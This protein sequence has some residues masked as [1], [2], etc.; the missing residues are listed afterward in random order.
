MLNVPGYSPLETI[1]TQP[2]KSIIVERATATTTDKPGVSVIC[3]GCAIADDTLN[4]QINR[5]YEV[6]KH[7]HNHA[8]SLSIDPNCISAL[9]SPIELIN[10]KGSFI[11]V[12]EDIGGCSL[13]EYSKRNPSLYE[14][15]EFKIAICSKIASALN[16][17]HQAKT[18]HKDVNPDNIVVQVSS[19]GVVKC[20]L[21]DFS[22]AEEWKGFSDTNGS[23]HGTLAYMA[24]EQTGRIQVG[25]DFRTA[26]EPVLAHIAN[27]KVPK[28]ISKI[29]DRMIAKSPEARYQSAAGLLKDLNFCDSQIKK[30]LAESNSTANRNDIAFKALMQLDDFVLGS[31]DY[32]KFLLFSDTKIVGRSE[33]LKILRSSFTRINEKGTTEF[34]IIEGDEGQGKKS[35]LRDLKKFALENSTLC[36]TGNCHD[37]AVRP[38]EPALLAAESVVNQVLGMS[39]EKLATLAEEIMTSLGK[40]KL[41]TL[42]SI[43]PKLKLL[44]KDMEEEQALDDGT[45]SSSMAEEALC[46]FF[47][48]VSQQRTIMISLLELENIHERG[49]LFLKELSAKCGRTLIIGLLNSKTAKG[50]EI[51]MALENHIPTFGCKVTKILLEPLTTN[52]IKI[53]LSDML[54]PCLGNLDNLSS[55]VQKRTMGV[56]G[57]IIGFLKDAERDNLIYFSDTDK[58]AGW[59]WDEQSLESKS[60]VRENVISHLIQGIASLGKE[61]CCRE[62]FW[63]SL[64]AELGES[65]GTPNIIKRILELQRLGYIEL[66]SNRQEEKSDMSLFTFVHETMKQAA[67]DLLPTENRPRIHLQIARILKRLSLASNDPDKF[68]DDLTYQYGKAEE[69]IVEPEEVSHAISVAS[70]YISK[71]ILC[72]AFELART[73]IAMG[74]RMLHKLADPWKDHYATTYA[75]YSQATRLASAG[76]IGDEEEVVINRIMVE[77]AMTHQHFLLAAYRMGILLIKRNLWKEC[78]EFALTSLK[79]FGISIPT[80]KEDTDKFIA[81]QMEEFK[82]VLALGNFDKILVEKKKCPV[83]YEIIQMLLCAGMTASAILV[84]DNLTRCFSTK[85]TNVCIKY[86]FCSSS[87]ELTSTV[88]TMG[89]HPTHPNFDIFRF[90]KEMFDKLSPITHPEHV[91]RGLIFHATFMAAFL[92]PSCETFKLIFANANWALENRVPGLAMW[93]LYNALN[94]AL[95]FSMPPS[96]WRDIERRYRKSVEDPAIPEALFVKFRFAALE[97]AF[98]GRDMDAFFNNFPHFQYNA[99]TGEFHVAVLI[100]QAI[101]FNK[102]SQLRP[103]LDQYKNDYLTVAAAQPMIVDYYLGE[104]LAAGLEYSK[105]TNQEEKN[106]LQSKMN[107]I[108][109]ILERFTA[110]EPKELIGKYFLASAEKHVA[111]KNNLAALE[112][113]ESAIET[114]SR[115]GQVF[116]K[117]ISLE[118]LGLFLIQS[119]LGEIGRTCII[120]SYDAWAAWGCETKC[121]QMQS[122]YNFNFG[123]LQHKPTIRGTIT[124]GFQGTMVG[125]IIENSNGTA[126]STLD[127]TLQPKLLNLDFATLL[128]VTESIRN[129][130][131]LTGLL[132]RIMDNVMVNAGATKGALL[133]DE[134][135]GIMIKCIAT[136][137]SG[138]AQVEILEN[139]PMTDSSLVPASMIN[140]SFRSRESLVASDLAKDLR[141]NNDPYI[142]LNKPKTVLCCPI[143]HYSHV[144]G[145]VYLENKLQARTFT[146]DR[147]DFLQSLMP[148]TSMSIENARLAKTNTELAM[149]LKNTGVGKVNGPRYNINAPVQKAIEILQNLKQK[150]IIQ[151]DP[152]VT[153]IDFI[154]N[155]LI[156]SDL[157]SSSI[158]EIND[159]NG[160]G[161]D[162]DTKSW[163]ETSLLQR[164][165]KPKKSEANNN[166][167]NNNNGQN[168]FVKMGPPK[169]GASVLIDDRAK[170]GD[171]TK[172]A[173]GSRDNLESLV[174]LTSSQS[175]SEPSNQVK[176]TVPLNR[177]LASLT[178]LN[179]DDIES[180]LATS[181]TSLDFDIFRLAGL[182]NGKPLFYLSCYMMEVLGLMEN[183]NINDN[184]ARAFFEKVENSYHNLPYHNSIHASDV[185]QTVNMLLLSDDSIS[186]NFTK[187]EIFAACVASAVHDIDHPGVN[188]AFLVQSNHPMAIMYND[189]AVLESH[190][191]AKAFEIASV[192]EL[193]IFASLTVDQRREARKLIIA[194]VIATDMSQHFQYINKLKG[195]IAASALKWGESTDRALILEIAIK[196]GDL[197]NPTKSLEL[198]KQWSFRVMD[199]FFKQ[200][201]KPF[202]VLYVTNLDERHLMFSFL[203]EIHIRVIEKR[204]QVSKFMDRDDTNIAKCQIGFID[205]LVTPLFDILSQSVSTEFTKKCM[206]N[207]VLNRTYWES[208]L[209]NPKGFP[210]FAKLDKRALSRD[211]FDFSQDQKGGSKTGSPPGRRRSIAVTGATAFAGQNAVAGAVGVVT[212]VSSTISARPS[213]VHATGNAAQPIQQQSSQQISA[214]PPQ[215]PRATSAADTRSRAS[216]VQLQQQPQQPPPQSQPQPNTTT[217]TSRTSSVSVTKPQSQQQQQSQLPLP[218]PP[219]PPASDTSP[220]GYQNRTELP[221]QDA[222]AATL[223]SSLKT[224]PTQ[225]YENIRSSSQQ[226]QPP[227]T[228]NPSIQRSTRSLATTRSNASTVTLPRIDAEQVSSIPPFDTTQQTQQTQQQHTPSITNTPPGLIK[229]TTNT[230]SS[231]SISGINPNSNSNITKLRNTS[232]ARGPRRTVGGQS[233]QEEVA[234]KAAA[235]GGLPNINVNAKGKGRGITSVHGSNASIRR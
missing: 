31:S 69:L 131:S 205:I 120:E 197:N 103:H 19:E 94:M 204:H 196:C 67:Y 123:S 118:R 162:H 7:I 170:R 226:P 129:E 61:S 214:N 147:V 189:A 145:V 160:K 1:S 10:N 71:A 102:I 43:I 225:S 29:I 83:K 132:H 99:I 89:V 140:F 223:K 156:S 231:M 150:L 27:P 211:P 200:V 139:V 15:L 122:E 12:L 144:T 38:L 76:Q 158:D 65:Q 148:T 142:A 41:W 178:E 153:Q 202:N 194:M 111:L 213:V 138:S 6:L 28:V 113:F 235:G 151:K 218:P 59:T 180:F 58:S 164:S 185:L 166:S 56:P 93:L 146:R 107:E 219:L 13:R 22:L 181:T 192:P 228:T 154:L 198:S 173:S 212:G 97:N 149:A 91:C 109:S 42:I 216:K 135:D 72:G 136:I 54:K 110:Q 222:V 183:F 66:S 229:N 75:F 220:P 52:V 176:S 172:P 88:G 227:S 64:L 161:I 70:S 45:P 60:Y 79:D 233:I 35:L 155:S 84:R 152:S 55:I 46:S 48:C 34:V 86:G 215:Y 184:I 40:Y 143:V 221:T 115:L 116:L 191:A 101:A 186:R 20:Q 33:E 210:E 32:A 195:K 62:V 37:S 125:T 57:Q 78:L 230:S 232:S 117:A 199:E 53:F 207:I 25:I 8:K 177:S 179:L 80:E 187:L 175:S 47:N 141:F 36:V 193:D 165:A 2:T 16:I 134:P 106:L 188:N 167:N 124:P 90:T 234:R 4:Y 39:A 100:E 130:T 169:R 11:L 95:P 224:S 26:R 190:H 157:F 126:H 96:W 105:C 137:V 128:K 30:A 68:L 14:T 44:F 98:G 168:K 133:L 92:R 51:S 74:Q 73:Y 24:P 112:F 171:V 85:G 217:A 49:L 182:T 9:I 17:I 63:P 127:P 21:I 108:E 50:E 5:E 203:D 208:V 104:M 163:I 209:D 174:S 18:V 81:T 201:N 87:I 77:N 119:K 82:A 206:E 3:K 114:A 23:L 159:E 121:R